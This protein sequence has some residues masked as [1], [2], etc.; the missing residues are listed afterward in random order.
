M[1]HSLIMKKEIAKTLGFD[2]RTKMFVGRKGVIEAKFVSVVFLCSMLCRLIG[3][4]K[5]KHHMY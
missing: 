5:L 3:D 4:V 2:I 1:N